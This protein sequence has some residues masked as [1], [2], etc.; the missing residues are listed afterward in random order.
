[1]LLQFWQ[2]LQKKV[3]KCPPIKR[4]SEIGGHFNMIF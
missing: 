4:K 2:F 3:K 1:M